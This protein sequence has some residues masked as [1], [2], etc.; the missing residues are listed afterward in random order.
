M[1]P[2]RAGGGTDDRGREQSHQKKASVTS[3]QTKQG[4]RRSGALPRTT[5]NTP[6]A[7][8][9]FMNILSGV[10]W[11]SS[12]R[13]CRTTVSASPGNSASLS[14][15]PIVQLRCRLWRAFQ[16]SSLISNAS[17]NPG[18]AMGKGRGGKRTRGFA[19][20]SNLHSNTNMQI[21]PISKAARRPCDAMRCDACQK[22]R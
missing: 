11:P 5:L 22:R 3:L 4:N 21:S 7:M 18:H 10:Q 6:K 9:F 19:P 8:T 12:V 1:R 13:A 15:Y 17:Q 14:V 2:G 20:F 16:L